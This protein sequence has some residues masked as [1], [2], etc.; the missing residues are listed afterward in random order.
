MGTGSAKNEL[1]ELGVLGPGGPGVANPLSPSLWPSSENAQDDWKHRG[2]RVC[3]AWCPSSCGGMVLS[4]KA[5][6]LQA[7]F[8][9]LTKLG[10]SCGVPW[11]LLP[12]PSD[13]DSAS[14]AAA[15]LVLPLS[16]AV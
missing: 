15:A 12:Q 9:S 14:V 4:S 16:Y 13:C 5:A 1:P 3:G 2:K 10:D 6:P 8:L 7:W 11:D